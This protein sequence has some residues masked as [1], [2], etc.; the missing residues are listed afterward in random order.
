[1]IFEIRWSQRSFNDAGEIV[2]SDP[3][4]R[5]EFADGLKDMALE[6]SNR[7]TTASRSAIRAGPTC[8]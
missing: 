6:L 5:A 7:S 8:R 4:R 3:D 1:M 2:K